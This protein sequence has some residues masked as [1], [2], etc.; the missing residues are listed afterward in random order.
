[1]YIYVTKKQSKHTN[2]SCLDANDNEN[3]NRY[4]GHHFDKNENHL[5]CRC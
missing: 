3:E 2:T 5:I 4:D 1:M